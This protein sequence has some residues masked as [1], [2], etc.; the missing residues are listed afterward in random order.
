MATG[1]GFQPRMDFGELL[2]AYIA[3]ASPVGPDDAEH[4]PGDASPEKHAGMAREA[5]FMAY[6]HCLESDPASTPF[7]P[8]L[9]ALPTSMWAAGKDLRASFPGAYEYDLIPPGSIFHPSNLMPQQKLAISR[10]LGHILYPMAR[11]WRAVTDDDVEEEAAWVDDDDGLVRNAQRTSQLQQTPA[12][13][14]SIL[15]RATK[16]SMQCQVAPPGA[17]KTCIALY[18]ALLAGRNALIMTDSQQN[19]VQLINSI[20]THTNVASFFPVKLIRSNAKEDGSA[21]RVSD[22]MLIRKPP[23]SESLHVLDFGGIHG[24]GVVDVN[25]FQTLEHSS[26]DRS[27]L[28]TCLFRS[29]FDVFVVD[30]ADSVFAEEVRRSF[31]YG[32]VGQPSPYEVQASDNGIAGSLRYNIGYNKFVAMSGTWHRGDRAGYRFLRSLGPITYSIKSR[33]LEELELLAKMTVCLVRCSEPRPVV[34][35][36]IGEYSM[37][38]LTPEKMRI[39]ELIVRF[40]VSH[41]QKIMIFSNRHWHLRLIERLFPFALAPSGDTPREEYLAI[42]RRFKEG[43]HQLHPLVWVTINRGEIGFDV[44]DTSVVVN[45]V[46]AG[47]SPARLRQRM[48]RASRRMYKFGWFYDL[49]SDG[50]TE[51]AHRLAGEG[52]MSTEE[53]RSDATRYKLVFKDGYGPDLIRLTS[54][55]L[56]ERIEAHVQPLETSEDDAM[57]EVFAAASVLC[58]RTVFSTH[59]DLATADHLISCVWGSFYATDLQRRDDSLFDTQSQLSGRKRDADREKVAGARRE[60]AKAVDL[61]RRRNSML[62][63]NM[64]VPISKSKAPVALSPPASSAPSASSAGQPVLLSEAEYLERYKMPAIF[65]TNAPFR[66]ALVDAL[67]ALPSGAP[68]VP[69]TGVSDPQLL[70]VGILTLRARVNELQFRSDERRVSACKSLLQFGEDTQEKCTFLHNL[71]GR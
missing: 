15:R 21:H 45:L 67:S 34:S 52:A 58:E 4:L 31:L 37:E 14:Y 46:N 13:A 62:P 69:P 49:V 12:A 68:F 22:D 65:R 16:P 36:A 44:P 6:M 7:A 23:A 17:G 66:Q 2:S 41:G 27:M 61:K 35:K 19:E 11:D 71:G 56:S 40:H 29:H 26:M 25:M 5:D 59:C 51:W 54:E 30:E 28:R 32:V 3:K 55:E 43:V 60:R 10:A 42:E 64:R 33:Q 48:G 70:W 57:Q 53:L 1:S 8:D 38:T 39:L 63:K 24:I 50:E 20:A 18:I 47:E 9:M